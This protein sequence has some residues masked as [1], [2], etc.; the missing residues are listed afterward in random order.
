[1][2]VKSTQNVGIVNLTPEQYLYNR[3]NLKN[4]ID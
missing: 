1:M 4:F 3:E 2:P